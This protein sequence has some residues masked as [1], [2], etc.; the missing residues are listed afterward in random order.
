MLQGD[1]CRMSQPE[2]VTLLLMHYFVFLE[3]PNQAA[4]CQKRKGHR[5]QGPFLD[6]CSDTFAE[7]VALRV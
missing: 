4:R 3:L 6:L 5:L 2:D 7:G 1:E